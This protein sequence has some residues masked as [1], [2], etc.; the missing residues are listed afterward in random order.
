MPKK[1]RP[2]L[3][4][5]RVLLRFACRQ[6]GYEAPEAMLETLR[7][8]SA[9]V[10]SGGESGFARAL[11]L[12]PDR[13]AV[14][15]AR[16]AE[17]DANIAGH[18]R[19]L[20]M[21]GEHGRSWK[22]HQWLALLFTEHYLRRW[23]DDAEALRAE[24][25]A[26]LRDGRFFA[27]RLPAYAPDDLRT[28]AF[29]SAT[30][31]GKTLL[32]HAH[33]LQYRHH[34]RRAG[35]RL[36]NVVLVTPNEQLSAQH[37][38]E[39]RASGLHARL[40]SGAAGGDLAAPIAIIDLAKLAE[41]KGVKRVAVADFGE[42]NLVLVDEGHLGASGKAWRERR[43]ELARGGFAF[44]YSATFDQIAGADDGLASAYGK[45]LLFDYPYRAFHAEGY[46]KDYH[47]LNLPGGAQDDNAN[48]Y[49]TGCLL[50]FF[51]QS[52]LWREHGAAWREFEIARPLLAFLGKTV[53]GSSKADRA[54]RSD[55]V[56]ILE[57]LGRALARGDETRDRIA[58][59]LAGRSGLV[60]E[61]GNEYFA[62]RFPHV[63][64][65]GDVYAEL[66]ETL[67][68]GA[69]RLRVVY[70][71]AGAGELH[72]RV[73]DNPPFGVVNVGDS[74]GLHKLLAGA[75]SPDF[76]VERERGFAERLF[77]GVDRP[78]SPVNVVVGARR[79]I[80][81]WNSWRVSAMGLM[82][83]GVKE[84]PEIVQMFGRGVR[85]K[86][87]R[88]S[89]KRH[90]ACPGAP[91]AE[92][93]GGLA[94]LET[95]HI[96]GLRANY[97]SAFRELL[98]KQGAPLDRETIALKTKWTFPR[99][100]GLK[101]I[102]LEK[103]ADWAR[104]GERIALPPPGG[105][106][107][108]AAVLDLRSRLQA[109]ASA[110]PGPDEGGGDSL[111]AIAPGRMAFLD[112]TRIYDRL[113]ARKRRMGWSNLAIDRGTV[114]RLL[115]S[116]AWYTLHAPP[117]R[118]APR[119]F[120]GLQALEDVAVDLVAD[121]A[122]RF[123]RKAR[124]RWEHGRIEIGELDEA[125]PNNLRAYTV[126]VDARNAALAD[127]LRAVARHG[128]GG[129]DHRTGLESVA[130]VGAHA[131]EPLLCARADRKVE[132]RPAPLNRDEG[133]VVK[134]L[135]RLARKKDSRLGG[136]EL[137]LIRNVSRGGGLSFFDD[138]AYYPDFIVWLKGGA[139]QHMIFLDP[140]GLARLGPRERE[141]IGL[142]SGIKEVEKRARE[143]A[144]GLRLHAYILSATPPDGIDDGTRAQG[145]W[146]KDGVYFLADRD[147][148][149]KVA[150][151]ALAAEE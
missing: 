64:R 14:T 71:T 73:A 28:L 50:T 57:F 10:D 7:G 76:D 75:P 56:R 49:L 37:E 83:V 115:D 16:L 110:A 48:M 19:R 8:A 26:V 80:A 129:F 128:W 77:A 117:E 33:V 22:P 30:G 142:H 51:Q 126:E 93:S 82:H 94:L 90:R 121:Y 95:L 21:T 131:Y 85:L 29:Q 47:I 5:R 125:D 52:R 79:F 35:G 46:G 136:R 84:G 11:P 92:N 2:R 54:T 41:R 38:R 70:P 78:D 102:R 9:E 98:A 25:N 124:R 23:F 61:E 123:W 44:E 144:P 133:E 81:G 68:H 31:S 67:F 99:P 108:P 122:E 106:D 74:T 127:H 88:G 151:D 134:G 27:R 140:K 130:T 39:M 86:G 15:A 40:L 111:A 20:R 104:S 105:A 149:G 66:C 53:T 139:V 96:F 109:Q 147:C 59:L 150:A 17:Y 135:E 60:D 103:G 6:F 141:K 101:T 4:S 91:E 97:M 113:L 146:E 148:L 145:A 58:R 24:L 45:C 89:L 42:N 34:L 62:G 36:N 12:R 100:S 87:W 118:L 18:S 132:V 32:M 3:E 116:D 138:F 107:S 1:A 43:K 72:L 65:T 112:R 13:G 114:D 69:G 143:K 137:F 120:A 55:V 119:G 63:P